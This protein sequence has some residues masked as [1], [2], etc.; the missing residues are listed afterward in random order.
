MARFYITSLTCRV[1]FFTMNS[2]LLYIHNFILYIIHL[3]LKPKT[4]HCLQLFQNSNISNS[5]LGSNLRKP[6]WR[7][8]PY[9]K[10]VFTGSLAITSWMYIMHGSQLHKRLKVKHLPNVTISTSLTIAVLSLAHNN[11]ATRWKPLKDDGCFFFF[12][13]RFNSYHMNS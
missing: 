6:E 7:K 4:D 10:A 9:L 8:W 2:L 12:S 5:N 11:F 3:C 13:I 1:I